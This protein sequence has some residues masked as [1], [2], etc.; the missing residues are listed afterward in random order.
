MHYNSL[1]WEAGINFNEENMSN[2]ITVQPEW[3]ESGQDAV[4]RAVW[5]R[6]YLN[7]MLEIYSENG[8]KS[9]CFLIV[10]HAYFVDKLSYLCRKEEKVFTDL[11]SASFADVN[12]ALSDSDKVEYLA[13][14][15]KP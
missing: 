7:R 12:Q 2:E 13:A 15:P 1:F 10:T 3:P 9:V 5:L 4:K 6:H 14:K 8:T 11:P